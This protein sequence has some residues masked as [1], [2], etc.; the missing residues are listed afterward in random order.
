MQESI[1]HNVP[2]VGI[3]I[4]GDQDMNM[5]RAQQAGYGLLLEYKNVT[6]ESVQWALNT[7][8]KEKRYVEHEKTREKSCTYWYVLNLDIPHNLYFQ[9]SSTYFV[10]MIKE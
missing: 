4:I 6:S 5:H 9:Q 8:L 1:Y 3:P 7:V 2:V 10:P